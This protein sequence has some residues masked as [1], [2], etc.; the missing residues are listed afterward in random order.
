M[1]DATLEK[2]QQLVDSTKLQKRGASPWMR[3]SWKGAFTGQAMAR[4]ARFSSCSTCGTQ[5]VSGPAASLT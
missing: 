2:W 1:D 5:A 4:N 3:S